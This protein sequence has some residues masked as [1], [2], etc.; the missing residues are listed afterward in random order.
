MEGEEKRTHRQVVLLQHR[1][2]HRLMGR[3]TG[4]RAL[5]SML[6]SLQSEMREVCA[7]M[8]SLVGAAKASAELSSAK[9]IEMP[10]VGKEAAPD[11]SCKVVFAAEEGAGSRTSEAP[12]GPE[13]CASHAGGNCKRPLTDS[14]AETQGAWVPLGEAA[15]SQHH[16]GYAPD[17]TADSVDYP[18][19]AAHNAPPFP[20][21]PTADTGRPLW[22]SLRVADVPATTPGS[23]Q[24]L[25]QPLHDA[26]Q[27]QAQP[28]GG[29]KPRVWSRSMF[30]LAGE[31][32]GDC[33]LPGAS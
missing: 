33:E 32:C 25:L 14:Y 23:S 3:T 5:Q 7:A 20:R 9:K 22:R 6:G 18:Q 19:F 10:V 28:T 15:P 26:T 29:A 8:E 21:A 31:K 12:S 4:C 30:F 17:S 1:E 13:G 24:P 16:L 11:D 27:L 2:R